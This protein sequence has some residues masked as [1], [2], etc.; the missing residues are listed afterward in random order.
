MLYQKIIL[1]ALVLLSSIL[2]AQV[3]SEELTAAKEKLEE[4]RIEFSEKHIDYQ[5]TALDYANLIYDNPDNW[6]DANLYAEPAITFIANKYG[7]DS[8]IY[9]ESLQ[10][11][12][13]TLARIFDTQLHLRNVQD[14]LGINNIA[15]VELV[16][17]LAVLYYD[18]EYKED[19]IY[20]SEFDSDDYY[21]TNSS[22]MS[23]E[24]I[25]IGL[26]VLEKIAYSEN[27]KLYINNNIPP[28]FFNII[29]TARKVERLSST[30]SIA[31]PKRIDALLDYYKLIIRA[32]NS[33]CCETGVFEITGDELYEEIKKI[34]KVTSENNNTVYYQK[35]LAALDEGLRNLYLIETKYFKWLKNNDVPTDE[36]ISYF[37]EYMT[38]VDSI[39]LA[40]TDEICNNLKHWIL[41]KTN[42]INNYYEIVDAICENWSLDETE[43][44]LKIQKIILTTAFNKDG[45]KSEK[46]ALELINLSKLYVKNYD[47]ELALKHF[48]EAFLLLEELDWIYDLSLDT[49]YIPK[50]EKYLRTIPQPWNSFI[51][52]EFNIKSYKN[53]EDNTGRLLANA[54][55]Q[56]G[57]D[58]LKADEMDKK[59]KLYYKL[60]VKKLSIEYKYEAI[61]WLDSLFHFDPEN[62]STFFD[63]LLVENFS[64]AQVKYLLK[65]SLDSMAQ[66]YGKKS[67]EYLGVKELMADAYFFNPQVPHAADTALAMYNYFLE[68]YRSFEGETYGYFFLVKKITDNLVAHKSPWHVDISTQFFEKLLNANMGKSK[69]AYIKKYAD[70][71][72]KNDRFIAAEP[73][74]KKYFYLM[75]NVSNKR[76]NK[77]Y[78]EALYHTARIYRKTNRYQSA[79]TAYQE[80]E[81]LAHQN[82]NTILHIRCLD[83]L[84]LLY[85]QFKIY[86]QAHDYFSQALRTLKSLDKTSL[87]RF[88]TKKSALLYIKIKRHQGKLFFDEEDYET[89]QEYYSSIKQFE[90]KS[91]FV[92]FHRDYSLKE[93]LALLYEVLGEDKKAKKY[94]QLAI[95]QLT[96]KNELADAYVNFAKFHMARGEKKEAATY[97]LQAI[98]LD[99]AQIKLNYP[100]LSEEERLLFLEP[101]R[102]RI[103]EFGVFIV[104]NPDSTLIIQALNVHLMVKGLSLENTNNIQD[105]IL[106]SENTVLIEGYNKLLALRKKMSNAATLSEKKKKLRGLSI[107]DLAEQI[108]NLEKKLSRESKALRTIF[109]KENK[110]LRFKQLQEMLKEEEAAIDFLT[111]DEIDEYGYE[112]TNYYAIIIQPNIAPNLVLLSSEED[113]ASV[114]E[115]EVAPNTINYIT[116]DLESNYLYE[117]V[118]KPMLPYLSES[119]TLYICPTGILSKIAFQTL[120]LKDN[121]QQR[122]MDKWSLHYYSSFR[123]LLR[124]SVPKITHKIALVGGVKFS[125]TKEELANI[126]DAKNLNEEER[127]ELLSDEPIMGSSPSSRAARGEDFGYLL[128]TLQE[129]Q[130]IESL[131]KKQNWET[132]LLSGTNALEENVDKLDE[133]TPDILHIAT[134][135]FFFASTDESHDF[136]NQTNKKVSVENR[137]ADNKD[138]LLRS[139]LAMTGINVIWKDGKEIEGMEDGI[140]FAKEVAGMNLSETELVVLSACETGRGDI[141]NNE[142]IMGLQRAFK[143]AGAHKLIIS[144]WKVPDSQTS[145]LM[146]YFYTAYLE[147]NDVHLSFEIAQHT[148]EKKYKNP[149]YWAAFLLIE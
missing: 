117:L 47:E 6:D 147:N 33:E 32:E 29:L 129:V 119:K 12:P 27:G 131:F 56:A 15:Y 149:Y 3:S 125:L 55:L 101:I 142:G 86:D 76:K 111:I 141:D 91:P 106:N 121:G 132:T 85:Q 71:H 44:D 26:D 102:N 41:L 43:R 38:M 69:S 148:M 99:S 7:F 80:V 123:D 78:A 97:F 17:K 105:A 133:S 96:D 72:Y 79:L 140:L 23:Y 118:W 8:D 53:I 20:L 40:D 74:Y 13:S 92:S 130:T 135:G 112:V 124:V 73:L 87:S 46:Y 31:N 22:Y 14:S 54:Y 25:D 137:L 21:Q 42:K 114:L 127:E 24:L 62:Y 35:T 81:K 120:L 9:K 61:R 94:Y 19:Y 122:I 146:Q 143:T 51:R 75:K 49:V 34:L 109:D 4:K 139:G 107:E 113:I 30:L 39:S 18:S 88:E 52:N 126:A 104:K 116:D 63:D 37:R 84:G 10:K 48:V 28:Y 66:E 16:F 93:N 95:Q 144:L 1:L 11:V 108:K 100:N 36:L 77:N 57:W 65:F 90:S 45:V 134:H 5:L 145:E 136:L 60:G 138:P 58:L 128:G 83:D 68:F 110:Q 64:L 98:N 103:N 2:Q 59:A 89:A 115:S 82:K 70:W 67:L 50:F